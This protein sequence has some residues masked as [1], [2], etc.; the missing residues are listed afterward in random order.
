ML[1][2]AWTLIGR[3]DSV[4][5]DY[6]TLPMEVSRDGNTLGIVLLLSAFTRYWYYHHF[7]NYYYP[8]A[9][10][11]RKPQDSTRSSIPKIRL[12]DTVLRASPCEFPVYVCA[13]TLRHQDAS[14]IVAVAI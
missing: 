8:I 12:R 2:Y 6:V 9:Y 4:Y 14:A 11:P 1:L 5:F 10:A 3:L 7:Q 13:R